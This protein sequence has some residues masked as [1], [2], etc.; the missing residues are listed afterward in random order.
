LSTLSIGSIALSTCITTQ[1]RFNVIQE[2]RYSFNHEDQAM[3]NKEVMNDADKALTKH[4]TYLLYNYYYGSNDSV[5]SNTNFSLGKE[6]NNSI[7]DANERCNNLQFE[8]SLTCDAL[9]SMYRASS[10][11]VG[12]SFRR[13]GLELIQLLITILQHELKQ[14]QQSIESATQLSKRS[15]RSDG[16]PLIDNEEEKLDMDDI[17]Y[18]SISRGG[19]VTIEG[20]LLLRK[21]TKILAHYA[22]VGEATK[23]MAH[24][25]G[26]LDCLIKL[27]STYPYELVPWE[28]RLSALWILANLACNAENMSMMACT[29]DLIQSLVNVANRPLTPN[30]TLEM[31]MEKLRSRSI[32]SRAI[33]NLSWAPENKIRLAENTSLLDVMTT[34]C[35]L[36]LTPNEIGFARNSTTIQNIFDTT[37][38]YA[39]GALRNI[40]A[41]PRH[42]KIA[43]CHYRDGHILDVLTDAAWN[44]SDQ[45]VKDRALATIHNLA[46]HDTASLIASRPALVMILKDVLLSSSSSSSDD[47]TNENSVVRDSI[48][49]DDQLHLSHDGTPKQHAHATMLVLERTITPDMT[50]YENIRDLLDAINRLN[51][52]PTNTSITEV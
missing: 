13:L 23:P 47:I 45:H 36:R 46:V 1:E 5:I 7:D 26:L 9:E 21:A 41:A 20:D 14:R 30:D 11:V 28:A 31:M 39:V 27:V 8:V 37:R 50:C 15:K 6:P 3:H 42:V 4:L 52:E 51:T 49:N 25:P 10:A 22:R 33:L 40:A 19:I 32:A 38:R 2:A 43:L 16:S 34:L 35:V 48:K 29:T 12:V 17:I 44:D 18:Q 24:F